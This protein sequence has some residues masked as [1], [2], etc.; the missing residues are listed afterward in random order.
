MHNRQ[1]LLVQ[2]PRD[3]KKLDIAYFREE[4]FDVLD[5]TMPAKH[6]QFLARKITACLMKRLK[7]KH[8]YNEDHL[9]L[10]IISMLRLHNGT[11]SIIT[12]DKFG[13]YN[14]HREISLS[15]D[16][17]LNAPVLSVTEPPI[18]YDFVFN[19]NSSIC[20]AYLNDFR[21]RKRQQVEE[22]LCGKVTITP[23]IP[24]PP[25]I[26]RP[27]IDD[28]KALKRAVGLFPDFVELRAETLETIAKLKR[29]HNATKQDLAS[30]EAVTHSTT[31]NPLLHDFANAQVKKLRESVAASQQAL[32][33]HTQG[34]QANLDKVDAIL[35]ETWKFNIDLSITLEHAKKL[36]ICA[37]YHAAIQY[38]IHIQS[39]K[40]NRKEKLDELN[41]CFEGIIHISDDGIVSSLEEAYDDLSHHSNESLTNHFETIIARCNTSKVLGF[42]YG[43]SNKL[44]LINSFLEK[45]AILH[46]ALHFPIFKLEK[47][48]LHFNFS[49]DT[50]FAEIKRKT[51]AAH[52]QL[53]VIAAP[54]QSQLKSAPTQL[55]SNYVTFETRIN[56]RKTLLAI[57]D[58]LAK[59][60]EAGAASQQARIGQFEEIDQWASDPALSE[61]V[62][63]L[64]IQH[65]YE[66]LKRELTDLH[67]ALS[68]NS[69]PSA[70][71]LSEDGEHD[72]RT[73]ESDRRHLERARTA[74][75]HISEIN[76]Q[77]DVIHERCAELRS[78]F[79]AEQRKVSA[80]NPNPNPDP[81][82]PPSH[83]ADD[84]EQPIAAA[85]REPKKPGFF[86][87]HLGKFI[88]ASTGAVIGAAIGAGIGFALLPLTFGISVPLFAAIGGVIGGAVVG[89][90]VGVGIGVAVDRAS[91][92]KRQKKTAER[93][94]LLADHNDS[95]TRVYRVIPSGPSAQLT[96]APIPRKAEQLA[97]PPE[98][99]ALLQGL[100]DGLDALEA[101]RLRKSQ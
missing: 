11:Y 40:D 12:L 28:E 4:A 22:F 72:Q 98:A 36:L 14:I 25:T 101:S 43:K 70:T 53:E 21:K 49:Q 96:V 17:E 30:A 89:G 83:S 24:I 47:L 67:A 88:G 52:Q 3:R 66:A 31:A 63:P 16:T 20:D 90:G 60:R 23:P 54:L 46:P 7:D 32:E 71:R 15:S 85:P 9:P 58:E 56:T 65:Q 10:N 76:G 74:L 42:S 37:M 34:L 45:Y 55:Q 80:A 73:I 48:R 13:G 1:P 94:P 81:P 86:R 29:F 19:I 97:R 61:V 87:R 8:E 91:E 92:K 39:E 78:A 62:N 41:T 26:L 69:Q 93:K 27:S 68:R 51:D 82:L 79:I 44:S 84:F 50:I 38:Y 95:T 100:F 75:T 18:H 33:Q 2:Q 99:E 6:R 64:L 35:K 5:S 59:V 77:I 57:R